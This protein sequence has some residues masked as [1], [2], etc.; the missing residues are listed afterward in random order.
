M[1][2][3]WHECQGERD[4]EGGSVYRCSGEEMM[5]VLEGEGE[6]SEKS[7]L[8]DKA[9]IIGEF[10]RERRLGEYHA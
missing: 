10:R 5:K 6:V 9:Y 4:R 2:K 3:V 1:G 8:N 7:S